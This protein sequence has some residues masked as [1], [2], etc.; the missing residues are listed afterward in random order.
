MDVV[1]KDVSHR[2]LFASDEELPVV[3][4]SHGIISRAIPRP[5]D[6]SSACDSILFQCQIGQIESDWVRYTG[7]L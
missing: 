6:F 5:W 2:R 4:V 3:V 1:K 7:T